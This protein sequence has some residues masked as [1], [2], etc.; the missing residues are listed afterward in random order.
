MARETGAPGPSLVVQ[1]SLVVEVET[2]ATA[3]R[4]FRLA[5]SFSAGPGVTVLFGPSGSGKSMTLAAI[6]GL[7]RPDRGRVV[8]GGEVLFDSASG[9]DRPV[10]ERG[11]AIV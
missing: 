2:D 3:G 10:H 8:L 5:V 11:I 1:P 4:R 9:V 6:T 7:E